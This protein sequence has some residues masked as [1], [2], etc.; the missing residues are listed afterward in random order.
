MLTAQSQHLLADYHG[1]MVH[2][3]MA[4]TADSLQVFFG[5]FSS[6]AMGDNLVSIASHI[7][8]CLRRNF[9]A[10]LY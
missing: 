7:L 2:H 5:G 9:V 3:L 10:F 4:L 1:Q 8:P 6:V